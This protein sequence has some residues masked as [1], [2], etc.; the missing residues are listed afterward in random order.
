[1]KIR[2]MRKHIQAGNLE[3][4]RLCPVALALKEKG[5]SSVRVLNDHVFI[6]GDRYNI[7]RGQRFIHRFDEGLSVKPTV[8]EL[9]KKKV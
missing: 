5:Y 6:A 8:I 1:M 2:V 3:D 9:I 4:E 7:R